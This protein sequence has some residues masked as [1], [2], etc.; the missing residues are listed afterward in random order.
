MRART[1]LWA[2][3][4]IMV[5]CESPERDFGES[6]AS[7]AVSASG[8]GGESGVG[9]GGAGDGGA[10]GAG[11]DVGQG[12]A[13]GAGGFGGGA[14]GNGGG[15]DCSDPD[16][17]NDLAA[18]VECGGTD[19]DDK[20]PNV[21][22]EQTKFFEKARPNGSFDYNCNEAEEREFETV[23]CSGAFCTA[24]MNVFIGDP[25][26]PAAC[27]LMSSFG[28]CSGTCQTSNLTVKPM[29]CR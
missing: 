28:S 27:G 23:K 11:G 15:I 13:G 5:A 17:D 19:C 16:Q 3:V 21:F 20:D 12:G 6:G 7:S 10:G 22:A 24:K 25:A 26:A 14:G 18:A 4:V 2:P 9:G 29:R 8:S 1:L